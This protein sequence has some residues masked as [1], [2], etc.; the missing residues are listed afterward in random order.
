MEYATYLESKGVEV[1]VQYV[2]NYE[3]YPTLVTGGDGD[4]VKNGVINRTVAVQL[5]KPNGGG[6]IGEKIAEYD[7]HEDMND[8]IYELMC[9]AVDAHAGVIEKL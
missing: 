1:R 3:V 9:L 7:T 2:E 6:L 8:L 5:F 4:Y